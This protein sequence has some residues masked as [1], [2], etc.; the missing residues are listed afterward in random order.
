MRFIPYSDELERLDKIKKYL[1]GEYVF[2]RLTKTMIEKNNID[3]N[4]SF[5]DLL[6]HSAFVD[7]NRVENGGKSG[8]RY[9]SIFVKSSG[10]EHVTL[11]FYKVKGKRSDPR[12]SIEAI[13][14]KNEKRELMVDDLLLF[15]TIKQHDENKIVMINLTHNYPSDKILYDCLGLD[16]I[17]EVWKELEPK[18]RDIVRTGYHNN[19]KGLGKISPKDVGDTLES[20]LGL[21][22]NNSPLPDYNGIEIKA[23][24]G[25]TKDTL[26][27]LRPRFENT[28]IEK[29]EPR[30]RNRV[31]AFTRLYGYHS[32]THPASKSL[33]ITIGMKNSPQNNQGFYLCVNEKD[34]I[35]ELWR[36]NKVVAFWMFEELKKELYAK[37]PTTIWVTSESRMVDQMGQFKYTEIVMTRKPN[38]SLFISLIKEGMITYDWRGYTSIEGNYVG[39]NHGN[40]WRIHPKYKKFLFGNIEKII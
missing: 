23:K 38:F 35:V 20:L 4:Y 40:A 17:S 30:D 29:I 8:I 6:K 12:F 10:T 27:T 2:I 33:Y 39:K 13:K 7:F 34:E 3:V 24:I 26:F 36:E 32:K 9:E 16:K 19:S 18:L 15:S 14:N 11:N 28:E 5:R 21:S 1:D 31:S 37:H 22:V 25:K